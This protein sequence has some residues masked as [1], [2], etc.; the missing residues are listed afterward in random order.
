MGSSPS[1]K[2]KVSTVNQADHSGLK[3]N[4]EKLLENAGN[5][6]KPEDDDY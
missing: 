6:E 4:S 1:Y 2:P 5:Q 3:H